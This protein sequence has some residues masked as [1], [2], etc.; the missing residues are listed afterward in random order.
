MYGIIRSLFVRRK[1]ES[2]KPTAFN[3]TMLSKG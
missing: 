3:K 2:I 1:T